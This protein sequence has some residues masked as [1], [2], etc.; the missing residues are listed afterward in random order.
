MPKYNPKKIE[1][2]GRIHGINSEVFKA[3]NG[4]KERRNFT[5]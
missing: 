3:Q 5:F 4:S 1:L 2:N